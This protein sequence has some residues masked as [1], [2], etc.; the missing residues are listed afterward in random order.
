MCLI[1]DNPSIFEV[2]GI[3]VLFVGVIELWEVEDWGFELAVV[4]G[5]LVVFVEEPEEETDEEDEA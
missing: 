1:G 3:D 2:V 5:P 4:V